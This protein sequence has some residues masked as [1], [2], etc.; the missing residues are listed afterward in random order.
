[1]PIYKIAKESLE[2]LPK[3]KLS[4][5]GLSER[6][7]QT[8]IRDKIGILDKELLVI[9]EEFSDWEESKRRIDLLAIDKNANL[10]VIE[11]KRDESSHMELQALRYAAMVST[12][13]FEKAV[14]TYK[15]H[16][17]NLDPSTDVQQSMTDAQQSMLEFL[18]WDEPNE[19]SF[20]ED[21]KIILASA[22]FSKELTTAVLWLNDRDLSIRCFRL[23]PYSNG[24]QNFLDVQQVIPLSE[25]K[26][27]QD[28]V[29]EKARQGR[30]AKAGEDS[31]DR[32][33][34]DLRILSGTHR[35]LPKRNAIFYVI[36]YL[37]E[38]GNS[39]KEIADHLTTQRRTYNRLFRDAEG[40]L[41]KQ[42]FIE[43]MKDQSRRFDK[44]RWFMSDPDL[45]HHNGRTYVFSNQWGD[46][47]WTESMQTLK[48][49]YPD[50]KI[51]WEPSKSN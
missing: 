10:V 22:S 6:E 11:L 9:G 29:S 39:P 37:V 2:P 47:E 32:T 18:E 17:E 5:L 30:H 41:D 23:Q 50:M 38:A 3:V 28:R 15:K 31:R 25:A 51:S 24:D 21:V 44:R 12:M 13:T 1:M 27:Y 40:Q 48:S 33:R 7:L 49:Q 14:E 36:R 46:P 8:L 26:E 19:D 43:S 35:N 4:E 45:L 16:L 20:A 42:D 34:Y